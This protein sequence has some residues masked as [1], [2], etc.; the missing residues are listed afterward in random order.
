MPPIKYTMLPV[1]QKYFYAAF[2]KFVFVL[3]MHI[4]ILHN[5]I[6]LVVLVFSTSFNHKVN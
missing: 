6:F 5:N 4:Y 2:M 3:F 1:T